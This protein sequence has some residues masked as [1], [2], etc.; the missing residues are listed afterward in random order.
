MRQNKRSNDAILSQ[1]NIEN[2]DT[3]A[4]KAYTQ[5]CSF[6]FIKFVSFTAK[7]AIRG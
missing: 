3:G 2:L 6:G 7:K 5:V 1:L 4:P